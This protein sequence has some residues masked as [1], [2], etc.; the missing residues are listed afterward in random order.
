MYVL[1]GDVAGGI[2]S[3]GAAAL[4]SLFWGQGVAGSNDSVPMQFTGLI[5]D[6]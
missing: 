5:N 3:F 1:A 6:L 4:N 2:G